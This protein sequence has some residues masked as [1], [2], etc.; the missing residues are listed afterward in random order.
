VDGA[1]TSIGTVANIES[2]VLDLGEGDDVDTLDYAG[3]M[4]AVTVSLAIGTATGFTSI[5]GVEYV[6]GGSG[7]DALTGDAYHNI[8]AGG[9]GLDTLTGGDGFDSLDGGDGAD[10]LDGGAGDDWLIRGGIGFDTLT[11][12]TGVDRFE[13]DLSELNGDRITDYEAGDRIVLEGS[14]AGYDNVRLVATGADTGLQIDGNNDGS[15]ETVITLNGTISGTISIGSEPYT[16]KVNNV[17]RI[18]TPSSAVPTSGSDILKGPPRPTPSM[19]SRATTRFSG[20]PGMTHSLAGRGPT[21]SME[22]MAMTTCQ[23]APTATLFSEIAGPTRLKA[24][25]VTTRFLAVTAMTC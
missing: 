19:V 16:N 5:A 3:T 14:L 24:G 6:Y 13:G 23:A 15:F 20:S 10:S 9:D 17:I 12:G 11:G 1:I 4:E 2:V 25:A 22:V 18:V 7:N 8:I 21:R